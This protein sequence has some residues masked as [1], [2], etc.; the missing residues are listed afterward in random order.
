[1]NDS[2]LTECPHCGKERLKRLISAAAFRLKGAGWYETDFKQG[3]QRNLADSSSAKGESDAS[4]GNV[5]ESTASEAK[6]DSAPGKESG[7]ESGSDSSASASSS[8]SEDGIKGKTAS[9]G[10]NK[11]PSKSAPKKKPGDSSSAKTA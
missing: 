4:S 6:P 2:V 1:M 7:K 9:K 10:E 8:K 3:N 5:S 11:N